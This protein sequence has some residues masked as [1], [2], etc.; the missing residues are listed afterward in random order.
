MAKIKLLQFSSICIQRLYTI[1]VI[2]QFL[3]SPI[4]APYFALGTDKVQLEYC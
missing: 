3:L 2:G 4:A 1:I